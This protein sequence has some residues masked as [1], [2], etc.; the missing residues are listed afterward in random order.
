MITFI[1]Q[2]SFCSIYWKRHHTESLWIAFWFFVILF[3]H[4]FSDVQ[5][6]WELKMLFQILLIVFEK[7]CENSAYCVNYL[8][9]LALSN[10]A[11]GI[12]QELTGCRCS[13]HHST[14]H[15]LLKGSLIKPDWCTSGKLTT[16]GLC[17]NSSV[18]WHCLK[19]FLC[20]P[21]WISQSLT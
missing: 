7:I 8:Y 11:S 17:S 4:G 21:C 2:F 14:L 19:C 6:L 12:L 18:K 15:S 1:K 5:G 9:C 16:F 13:H 3:I 10:V 20:F